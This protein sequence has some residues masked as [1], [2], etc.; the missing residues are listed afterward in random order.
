MRGGLVSVSARVNPSTG[1][2]TLT[3]LLF[4][5]FRPLLTPLADDDS[6]RCVCS[7]VSAAGSH[8]ASDQTLEGN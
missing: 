4:G 7:L 2:Q 5:E 3:L 8:L 1:N 6:L